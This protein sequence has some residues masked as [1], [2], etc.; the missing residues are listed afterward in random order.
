IFHPSFLEALFSPKTRK[1]TAANAGNSCQQVHLPHSCTNLPLVSQALLARG[2][3]S[4]SLAEIDHA[5]NLQTAEYICQ[6][7]SLEWVEDD[8]TL[9]KSGVGTEE[10]GDRDGRTLKFLDKGEGA[11]NSLLLQVQNG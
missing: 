9:A 6:L 3:S 2:T 11:K 8:M 4:T 1:N 10:T 5:R 7:A